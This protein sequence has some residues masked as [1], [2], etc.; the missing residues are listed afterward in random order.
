ML[1]VGITGGMGSGKTTVARLFSLLDVPVYFADDMAKKL[2]N[3]D[4]VLR[5]KIIKIFGQQAY[6]EAGLNRT[7]IA[8]SAFSNPDMLLRLNEAVHPEVIQHCED[9]MNR[10][11]GPY[12]LKEAALIFES[13]SDKHLDLVIGVYA[14]KD[15]RIA[16]IMQRDK[17]ERPSIEA[18][19]NRQMDEDDKMKR[20]DYVI[21][22]NEQEALI[23]QVLNLHVLLRDRALQHLK[24]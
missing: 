23:P 7:F 9:W 24:Q 13:G 6:N 14:P 3:E 1:R 21:I 20:C 8:Q 10:Q 12:A 11:K 5:L 19:M 22:N 16:R 2:M 4:D 17:A 18:R 15:V